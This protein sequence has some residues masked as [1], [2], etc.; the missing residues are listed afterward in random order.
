[1]SKFNSGYN[2]IIDDMETL[3]GAETEYGTEIPVYD[4][5]YGKLYIL[6]NTLGIQ[7][8]V[9]ARSWH[10][11]YSI[12]EDEFMPEAD[13]SWED[14]AKECECTPDELMENDIFQDG[15]GFRPNGPNSTDTFKHGIYS[16]DINGEMLSGLDRTSMK[17]FDITVHI[18]CRDS[19]DN[20]NP[21]FPENFL[22]WRRVTIQ[23]FF[24]MR[25]GI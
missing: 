7:G 22:S 3:D 20:Y 21:K 6:R 13:M 11:A 19:I 16:K 10:D 12:C 5:G 17:L 18:S 1:M 24:T 2:G 4:D 15:Y 8:I 23:Q 14:I 25:E 9:R